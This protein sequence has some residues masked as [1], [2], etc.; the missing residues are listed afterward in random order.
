MI[1]YY[2]TFSA[3]PRDRQWLRAIGTFEATQSHAHEANV[4]TNYATIGA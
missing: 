2:P 4:I 3:S 1:T